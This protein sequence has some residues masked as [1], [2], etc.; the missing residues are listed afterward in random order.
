MSAPF[1]PYGRQTIDDGDIA[2]VVAALKSPLITQGPLVEVF[3]AGLAKYVDSPFVSVVANGTAALHVAYAA[4]GLG[5]GDEILTTPIT[6]A[7]TANAARYLGAEAR[8]ADVEPDTGNLDATKLE[9]R[10]TPRTRGIVAVHLGGLPCDLAAIRA[11]ADRHNLWVVEDASHALGAE[12]RGRKIGAGV[13]SDATTFSFHP[14][15]HLTTGEGGAIAV[16]KA[17]LKEAMDRLRHHGIERDASKYT[18][19]SP[20][21]WYHE[22]PV[23]GFNYRLTDLQCAL[24]I[25][26]L[27]R[28]PAGL[29]RRR[30]IAARYRRGFA[31]APGL[32]PQAERDERLSAYHLFPVRIGFTAAR[33]RAALMESLKARGI[34]TQVHYIPVSHQPY[35]RE[36]YGAPEA[37]AGADSYYERT[38]SLPMY[39]A[40]TDDDVDRVISALLSE[41]T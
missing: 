36:R 4:L 38:L 9:A 28:Q 10:I 31:G 14:V 33:T 32:I 41:L 26:Q 20:G 37:L 34:G 18:I 6:F 27:A 19:P 23:L 25:S 30:A 3:E 17:S 24:G 1:L 12:Y 21:P 11:I 5:A 35:Y 40:L 16:K 29:V 8:F 2:A 7:A 39:P 13:Y 22:M 15:K